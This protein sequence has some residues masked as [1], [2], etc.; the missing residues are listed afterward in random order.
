MKCPPL[1]AL[2]GPGEW[3]FL[4]S[5]DDGGAP[6]AGSLMNLGYFQRDGYERAQHCLKKKEESLWTAHISHKRAA[7]IDFY[8][9]HLDSVPICDA[10]A[11]VTNREPSV[12]SLVSFPVRGGWGEQGGGKER[13]KMISKVLFSSPNTAVKTGTCPAQLLEHWSLLGTERCHSRKFR[14]PPSLPLWQLPP[15]HVHPTTHTHLPPPPRS[16]RTWGKTCILYPKSMGPK[17]LGVFLMFQRK[18]NLSAC[19]AVNNGL[20]PPI[21]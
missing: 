4:Y 10:Q 1:S 17:N 5:G 3:S 7:G 21:L 18:A 6:P 8:S 20:S 13:G 15:P 9:K 16:T 12:W 11:V 14:K 19:A 2:F